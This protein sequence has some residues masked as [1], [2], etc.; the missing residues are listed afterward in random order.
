MKKLPAGLCF[1]GEAQST[2]YG[3]L[4]AAVLT[5]P[6]VLGMGVDVDYLEQFGTSL[7]STV[8]RVWLRGLS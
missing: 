1:D 2:V 5:A 4:T 7:V 6:S 8:L 3:V